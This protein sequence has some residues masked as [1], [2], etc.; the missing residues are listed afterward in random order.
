MPPKKQMTMSEYKSRVSKRFNR[1]PLWLSPKKG[2]SPTPKKDVVQKQKNNTMLR[3]KE[4]VAAERTVSRVIPPDEKSIVPFSYAKCALNFQVPG[5]L[6]GND[7]KHI[8][9]Y[10]LHPATVF[11]F[12]CHKQPVFPRHDTFDLSSVGNAW[13]QYVPSMKQVTDLV[14]KAASLNFCGRAYDPAYQRVLNYVLGDAETVATTFLH[15]VTER[16]RSVEFV[17]QHPDDYKILRKFVMSLPDHLSTDG[18]LAVEQVLSVLDTIILPTYLLMEDIFKQLLACAPPCGDLIAQKLDGGVLRNVPLGELLDKDQLRHDHDKT[19]LWGKQHGQ[20]LEQSLQ[21]S[22]QDIPLKS[23]RIV[24]GRQELENAIVDVRSMYISPAYNLRKEAV[25]ALEFAKCF[26]WVM[27][28]RPEVVE[29]P[30]EHEFLQAQ[31]D[32]AQNTENYEENLENAAVME[33]IENAQEN[34][35]FL[36][37]MLQKA[38]NVENEAIVDLIENAENPLFDNFNADYFEE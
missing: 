31:V 34:E 14:D 29:K 5:P 26:S 2:V 10:Y 36:E 22:L 15:F 32:N 6:K 1:L 17:V 8:W 23:L 25:A 21:T 35:Q 4:E 28:S 16:L 18:L 24:R 19:G 7:C 20:T 30:E 3:R 27:E 13:L 12:Y 33:D 11:Y 9:D 38:E 37:T